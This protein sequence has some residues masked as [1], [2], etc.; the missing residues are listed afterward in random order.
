MIVGNDPLLEYF[1]ATLLTPSQSPFIKLATRF[2]TQSA[3]D[4]PAHVVQQVFQLD[5][6]QLN[7]GYQPNFPQ[8]AKVVLDRIRLYRHTTTDPPSTLLKCLAAFIPLVFKPAP[9]PATLEVEQRARYV[10]RAFSSAFLGPAVDRLIFHLLVHSK[11]SFTTHGRTTLNPRSHKRSLKPQPSTDQQPDLP[12]YARVIPILQSSGFGKTK[13]C[14]HLSA[15]HPG[16][17][18]CLRHHS[19]KQATSFPPQDSLVYQYMRAC[20][21]ALPKPHAEHLDKNDLDPGH[22]DLDVHFRLANFLAAYCSSLTRYLVQL[23]RLSGCYQTF[24]AS[25]PAGSHSSWSLCWKT[26]VYVLST[27]LYQKSGFLPALA[28]DPPL[29]FCSH[30]GTFKDLG[31][32]PGSQKSRLDRDAGHDRALTQ[33][34]I[35][36]VSSLRAEDARDKLISEIIDLADLGNERLQ[37]YTDAAKMAQNI[38]RPSLLELE[39]LVEKHDPDREAMFHLALDE[40]GSIESLLPHLRRL[41]NY[42]EPERTWIL[43]IDTN[44]QISPVA[45]KA[46]SAASSRTDLF[47]GTHQLPLPFTALPL[48]VHPTHE[49]ALD[50]AKA[51]QAGKCSLR[52]LNLMIPKLGRPLWNDNSLFRDQDYLLRCHAIIGKLV[53]GSTSWRWPNKLPDTSSLTRDDAAFQAIMA[54]VLQRVPMGRSCLSE[55][56]T[57]QEFVKKQISYNLRFIEKVLPHTN[58]V[59]SHVVSEPPLSVAAAWS[60]RHEPSRIGLKW[61]TAIIHLADARTSVGL[62]VG[63]EG[64]EGVQLLCTIAADFAAGEV[65]QR[66]YPN[67]G[68]D[69]AFHDRY[70]CTMGL[71][72]LDQ[73]LDMLIG[74]QIDT[75]IPIAVDDSPR[76]AASYSRQL[77][78]DFKAWTKTQWLN[79]KHVADLPQE[80]NMAKCLDRGLLAQFWLRHAAM[81]GISTQAGWDLL[82]PVYH[83]VQTPIGDEPFEMKRLSFVAIQVKNELYNPKFPNP[84]GPELSADDVDDA[85]EASS[86]CN[87]TLELYLDLRGPS[88]LPHLARMD[89][90]SPHEQRKHRHTRYNIYVSGL[91]TERYPVLNG[92][93]G[94]ARGLMPTMFGLSYLGTNRFESDF[95]EA[96]DQLPQEAQQQAHKQL[97]ELQGYMPMLNGIPRQSPQQWRRKPF[98]RGYAVGQSKRMRAGTDV[99]DD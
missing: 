43:L 26:L 19:P 5:R 54:L 62:Q 91:D 51:I 33:H 60:F 94:D 45:G 40:C 92:L 36:F 96:V 41:W 84:L 23:M 29:D 55:Q 61:S 98:S 2:L 67:V 48:D 53:G 32:F 64:E 80:V 8:T 57:W 25:T 83:S 63:L 88:R 71:V 37:V 75:S 82:V 76:Q 1:L 46:A 66:D 56:V 86:S 7:S 12:Y 21:D 47:S 50:L 89:A 99:P 87:T 31:L 95:I 4:L 78:Q 52:R 15:R 28:L 49:D 77:N 42:A 65:Y 44:S 3:R 9:P 20:I 58:V 38:I 59:K 17:L 90:K 93:Q 73:W 70:A 72:R 68:F 11:H 79:F 10:Q 35:D 24:A 18:L 27:S 81:R 6:L 13:M 30:L 97:H 14:I 74:S 39:K 85:H 22:D 34:Q 16:L 69:D